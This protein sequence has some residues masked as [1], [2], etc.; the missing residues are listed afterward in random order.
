MTETPEGL[1]ARLAAAGI[2]AETHHHPPVFTVAESR[3]LRGSLPGGHT[4]NLFL[5]P[6]KGEGPFLLATLEE[7]RQVSVNALARLA[8]AGKVTMASA[9]ELVAT[10]GVPPGSV[11]PLGLVNAAPGAVRFVMDR[12]LLEGFDRIWVHPLTNAASTGMAPGD[13]LRFLA[14]CGHEARLLDLG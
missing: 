9:E 1:L 5:R 12:H 4:K 7:E 14:G 11:T 10:L 8:E 3:A 6:A 2:A 13:L